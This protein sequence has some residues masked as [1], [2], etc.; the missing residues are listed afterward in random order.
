MLGNE[1]VD[2]V[3]DSVNQLDAIHLNKC[4]PEKSK[5]ARE[6]SESTKNGRS[7][8]KSLAI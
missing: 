5:D 6:L 8:R 2:T 1:V 7:A 3:S 4:F